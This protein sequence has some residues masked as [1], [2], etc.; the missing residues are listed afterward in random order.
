MKKKGILN[1]QISRIL[2][3]L[4]GEITVGMKVPEAL[5]M[6]NIVACVEARDPEYLMGLLKNL[7][8]AE[9]S[10]ATITETEVSGRKAMLITPKA[11]VP[12]SPVIA[13]DGDVMVIGMSSTAL[14]QALKAKA[15]G[16]GIANTPSFKEALQG[17]PA[18]SNVAL[19]YIQVSDLGPLALAGLGMAA[20]RAPE[21]AKP[22]VDK[23]MQYAAE[24]VRD[25]EAYV[26]V[27]YRTPSG[28]ALQS[29]WGTRSVM[30]ILRNGTAF[31]AKAAMYFVAW[32]Q[33][34]SVEYEDLAEEAATEPATE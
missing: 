29:R 8:S 15:N 26:E 12:L 11:P 24:A 18:G 4:G 17:L 16:Q 1:I 23:A 22:V 10:P 9:E 13:V 2:A 32:R 25:L 33:V 21:E 3:S 5:A 6:P 34:E 27:M 30:Q 31:A 14:E 7:L 20:M 19:E 28:L